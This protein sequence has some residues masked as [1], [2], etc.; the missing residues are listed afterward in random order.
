M[1]VQC[2]LANFNEGRLQLIVEGFF[3]KHFFA[4]Y[5]TMLKTSYEKYPSIATYSVAG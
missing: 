1:F 2:Q 3:S 5:T 4:W